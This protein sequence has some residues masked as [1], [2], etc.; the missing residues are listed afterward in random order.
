MHLLEFFQKLR[1]KSSLS[2]QEENTLPPYNKVSK[3]EPA[4]AKEFERIASQAP[5]WAWSTNECRRWLKA[6][7][8]VY[9]NCTLEKAEATALKF[10]RFGPTLYMKTK[11][12][13][14]GLLGE[15][16]R[17]LYGLILSRKWKKGAVPSGMKLGLRSKEG[18]A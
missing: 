18:T 2:N 1:K 17:G 16:G 5:Q 14:V 15:N 12:S 11:E 10:E 8:V 6:V 7:C 13:W 4:S 9:F 3:T